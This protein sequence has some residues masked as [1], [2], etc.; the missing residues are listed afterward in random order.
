MV[1]SWTGVIEGRKTKGAGMAVFVIGTLC[2][3]SGGVAA[4]TASADIC[5]IS[6]DVAGNYKVRTPDN[7]AGTCETKGTIG[8]EKYIKIVNKG[9]KIAA[10]IACAKVSEANTGNFS[11]PACTEGVTAGTGSYIKV[12]IGSETPG[13]WTVGG[14]DAKELS[15]SIQVTKITSAKLTLK[16]KIGGAEVKLN[17]TTTPT[18]NGVKLTGEGKF[19]TG[20]TATFKGVTTEL[21]G[22]ASPVC[23]LLG[24]AGNDSTLGIVT[25]NKVKAELALH[26]S[27]G[28]IEVKPETGNIFGVLFFGGLCALPEEVPMITRT[29]GLGLVLTD[30]LGIGNELVEHEFTELP[31][32]TELW[33]ISATAEHKK[34]VEGSLGIGL[35]FPHNALKWRGTAPEYAV[36]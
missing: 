5:A 27:T 12:K 1:R 34:E 33:V 36:S 8:K 9:P 35:N 18:L 31:A 14:K 11:N 13:K 7:S 22:K 17:T 23:A 2:A 10:G 15:A 20:G 3:I 29:N 30:S 6:V 4:P 16:T 32:L 21:N 28:V 25:T 24:T 19:I 26:E